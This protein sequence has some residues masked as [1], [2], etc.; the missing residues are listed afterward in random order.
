MIDR[1]DNIVTGQIQPNIA[2]ETV[3]SLRTGVHKQSPSP[4]LTYSEVCSFCFVEA[5][6]HQNSYDVDMLGFSVVFHASP[7]GFNTTDTKARFSDVMTLTAFLGSLVCVRLG[8]FVIPHISLSLCAYFPPIPT[9][10]TT[11]TNLYS[12]LSGLPRD[13]AHLPSTPHK[14]TSVSA[15]HITHKSVTA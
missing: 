9:S 10:K 1:A 8:N 3:I 6:T 4:P 2:D 14:T 7:I 13:C 12:L 11:S 15:E 5:F